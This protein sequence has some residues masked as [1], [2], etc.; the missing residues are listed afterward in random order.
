MKP[1]ASI[2]ADG[3][4]IVIRRITPAD[5]RLLADG[6]ARLSSESRRLRFLSTKSKLTKKELRYLTEV[7]GHNHEALVAIDPSTDQGVGVA[8]FVRDEQDLSRAEIAVVVADDWQRQGVA[9]LLLTRLTDRAR[10]E[11]VQRF[12]A[13]IVQENRAMQG[14]FSDMGKPVRMVSMGPGAVQYEI[15]ITPTGLGEQLKEALRAAATGRLRLASPLWQELR[16]LFPLQFRSRT[17]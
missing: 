11:G 7:D 14:L 2:L 5:S 9:T 12:T 13:L 6:F 15:E 4:S 10:Q 17:R 3:R 1:A 16:T 8:R